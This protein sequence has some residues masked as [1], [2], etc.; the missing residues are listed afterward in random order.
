MGFWGEGNLLKRYLGSATER[1]Q[2][3]QVCI[4]ALF[5]G[6]FR[7]CSRAGYQNALEAYREELEVGFAPYFAESDAPESRMF[8]AL[9]SIKRDAENL[10]WSRVRLV[11]LSDGK[12]NNRDT[13]P[14]KP[15]A[16]WLMPGAA[17]DALF[18][19][20]ETRGA[21]PRLSLM[22]IVFVGF[23]RAHASDARLASAWDSPAANSEMK[24]FWSIYSGKTGA[25]IS[26]QPSLTTTILKEGM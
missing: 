16:E 13:A 18:Q 24:G 23:G 26:F 10:G 12:A 14:Y 19:A 11:Y 25:A 4:S 3:F 7:R 20:L 15:G 2:T 5:Q 21:L 6:G 1:T 22:E 9:A 8:G 17:Q